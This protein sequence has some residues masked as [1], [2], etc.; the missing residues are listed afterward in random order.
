MSLLLTLTPQEEI[1][2]KQFQDT[3]PNWEVLLKSR[4]LPWVA[5]Y[6]EE[7]N[8]DSSLKE[9]RGLKTEFE[10]FRNRQLSQLETLSKMIGGQP[11]ERG[12]IAE[13]T[14]AKIISDAFP[15][16]EIQEIGRKDRR[17]DLLVIDPSGT[18]ILVEVKNYTSNI[19]T[20]QLEKF[21]RD[22]RANKGAFDAAIFLSTGS[23]IVGKKGLTWEV[24]DGIPI[25]YSPKTG[26]NHISI[27]SLV[28]FTLA[29]LKLEVGAK[30]GSKGGIPV[31]TI[32]EVWQDI[33]KE[34]EGLQNALIQQQSLLELVA[35]LHDVVFKKLVQISS[36]GMDVQRGLSEF[37]GRLRGDVANKLGRFINSTEV[38]LDDSIDSLGGER[39]ILFKN[40][41]VIIGERGYE[42]QPR[43][44]GF[45]V[46][47]KDGKITGISVTDE[48]EAVYL[49]FGSERIAI[50]R[51]GK[52]YLGLLESYLG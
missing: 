7:T 24:Y 4:I 51:G 47:E 29:M 46:L 44:K 22:L 17:T 15:T 25:C 23:G 1:L 31:A 37:V 5:T 10:I 42:M 33:E 45:W 26:I 35:E 36:K 14:V 32:R 18:R 49:T 39:K 19:G 50:E 40:I 3:H 8:D 48:G 11:R 2:I 13:E 28:A 34:I 6:K 38:S 20:Q 30:S 16:Y 41:S 9:L 21:Y 43:G 27:S 52:T 12:D